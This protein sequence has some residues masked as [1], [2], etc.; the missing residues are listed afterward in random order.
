MKDFPLLFLQ[1]LTGKPRYREGIVWDHN[2]YVT[3]IFRLYEKIF[4]RAFGIRAEGSCHVW[5]EDGKICIRRQFFT[6]EA[7]L[8]H[9]EVIGRSH[10]FYYQSLFC[11]LPLNYQPVAITFIFFGIVITL[12]MPQHALPLIGLA[13]AYDNADGTHE[14]SSSSASFSY[15]VTGSQPF[16][17]LTVGMDDS[18]SVNVSSSS[19][20]SV[21]LSNANENGTGSSGSH[22][23]S[24]IWSLTGPATGSNTMSV[25]Y[26]NSPSTAQ[27]AG[28]ISLSGVAQSGAIDTGA[29]TSLIANSSTGV[30]LT[31]SAAQTGEWQISVLATDT[32]TTPSASTNQNT[33]WSNTANGFT[34][35]FGGAA[36]LAG[37]GSQ[38]VKWTWSTFSMATAMSM[39][40]VKPF[41]SVPNQIINI[42]QAP[43]RASTY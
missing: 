28:V 33:R 27:V 37:S 7:L 41:V 15:T 3:N 21:A 24:F 9:C 29:A 6:F 40:F 36:A 20:N 26:S 34:H 16:L 8:A 32:V 19:Y 38:Q 11:D 18:G 35:M 43:N 30:S 17:A 22:K 5:Q 12:S 42:N 25:T 14:S 31:A 39:I 1:K 13:I 10:V 4:G 2:L 23:K